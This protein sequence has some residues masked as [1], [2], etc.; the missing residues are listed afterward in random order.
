MKANSFTCYFGLN[1]LIAST[2]VAQ[3]SFRLSNYQ[4]PTVNAPVYDALG[5][6]LAG[7]TY[8]AELWGSVSSNS[9]SPLVLIDR[10]DNREIV[11]FVTGGYFLPTSS[12]VRLSV[13]DVAPQGWAWLQV[14][15]WDARLGSTFE[16]VAALGIGGYGESPLFYAQGGDPFNQFPTPAP[17]L[18][19][20]SFSLR[21]VVPEP[22][23]A[24]LLGLGVA[25]LWRTASRKRCS[26]N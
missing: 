20:Q 4:P 7:S 2:L 24:A 25:S 22:S 9:L 11:P 14:R 15:A 17:L 16:Q 8:L 23:A 12:S 6:P 5:D 1:F 10:G 13:V 3:S 19:L 21:P 26:C 18:G